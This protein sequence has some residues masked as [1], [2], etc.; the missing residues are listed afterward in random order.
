MTVRSK[1][2][3]VFS[4]LARRYSVAALLLAIL[5][6]ISLAQ[7]SARKVVARTAPT[8]PELAKKMHLTGKVKIEVAV[9]PAGAVTS[10][11]LVGGNPVFETSAVDA[12]KQWKFEPAATATK[13]I[14]VLEFTE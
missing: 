7:E 11:K 4:L 8:Y 2:S 10:A 6:G 3:Q 5:L 14:V 13:G 12:V 9:N 1:F